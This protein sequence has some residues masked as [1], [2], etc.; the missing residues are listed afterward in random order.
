MS[1]QERP[2]DLEL[3]S[4]GW[5]ELQWGDVSP[6]PVAVWCCLLLDSAVLGNVTFVDAM[7]RI[8]KLFGAMSCSMYCS[9]LRF[10]WAHCSVA[11]GVMV[12]FGVNEWC[13]LDCCV[14]V[15]CEMGI[16][17]ITVVCVI[18]WGVGV[19]CVVQCFLILFRVVEAAVRKETGGLW[20]TY[21]GRDTS[22]FLR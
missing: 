7:S 9:V 4:I 13:V 21:W 2:A 20:R 1:T 10:G 17:L 19:F 14:E 6:R 16:T 3:F 18:E 15:V 11:E 5:S 12:A 22:S 8:V